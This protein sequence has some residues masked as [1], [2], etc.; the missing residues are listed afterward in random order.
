MADIW[1]EICIWDVLDT[2]YVLFWYIEVIWCIF[3][4]IEKNAFFCIFL[5]VDRH[6]KSIFFNF[7]PDN[8]IITFAPPSASIS[9]FPVRFAVVN[10]TCLARNLIFYL[11]V[12]LLVKPIYYRFVHTSSTHGPH[13]VHT[14]STHKVHIKGYLS[15]Y[16][17]LGIFPMS[18]KLHVFEVPCHACYSPMAECIIY[19][20]YYDWSTIMMST[21][22]VDVAKRHSR[23]S[24]SSIARVTILEER[25]GGMMWE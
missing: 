12:A 20:L 18:K 23:K 10:S 21:Q 16:T 2:F 15:I 25:K 8:R 17:L 24:L 11:R 1:P 3:G 14:W 7:R 9:P 5:A 4:K 13:I 19:G 22:R 6:A